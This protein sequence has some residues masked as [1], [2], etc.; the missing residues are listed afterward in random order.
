MGRITFTEAYRGVNAKFQR[1]EPELSELLSADLLKDLEDYSKL[2]WKIVDLY[3]EAYGE[4]SPILYLKEELSVAYQMMD[5]IKRL[6]YYQNLTYEEILSII[7]LELPNMLSTTTSTL[8][9]KILLSI[10][11]T[12]I[13]LYFSLGLS[14]RKRLEDFVYYDIILDVI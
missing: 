10:S 9:T 13:T 3:I 7:F 12:F 2:K 11:L 5:E 6:R 4:D 14:E 8:S 1:D